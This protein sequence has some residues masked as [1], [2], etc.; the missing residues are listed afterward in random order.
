MEVKD[1]V[2]KAVPRPH[3]TAGSLFSLLE[4]FARMTEQAWGPPDTN[5]RCDFVP[6]HLADPSH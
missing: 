6:S 4:S 5:D 2:T 1:N 3:S